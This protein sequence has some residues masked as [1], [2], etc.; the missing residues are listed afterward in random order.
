MLFHAD[1]AA[2]FFYNGLERNGF[3]TETR[4]LTEGNTEISL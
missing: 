3:T 1:V 2:I 4:R